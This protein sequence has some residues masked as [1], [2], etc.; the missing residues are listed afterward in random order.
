MAI[1]PVMRESLKCE[2]IAE[3][4]RQLARDDAPLTPNV[5][6]AVRLAL[7][8]QKPY[9]NM[10]FRSHVDGGL[11]RGDQLAPTFQDET[12]REKVLKDFQSDRLWSTTARPWSCSC[13]VISPTSSSVIFPIRSLFAFC[14]KQFAPMQV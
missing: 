5:Q 3:I 9:Y 13:F 8:C 1:G 14:Q 11:P 7:I 10:L 4:K 2:L 12:L 6:D